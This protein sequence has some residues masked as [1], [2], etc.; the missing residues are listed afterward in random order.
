[1]QDI[2]M[3]DVGKKQQSLLAKFEVLGIRD[4]RF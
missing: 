1:M 2:L 3:R 4:L